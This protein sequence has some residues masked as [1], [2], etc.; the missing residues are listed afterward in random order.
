MAKRIRKPKPGF[1]YILS[2][3]DGSIFKYGVSINPAKRAKHISNCCPDH[4]F[5]VVKQYQV[6]D[7]FKEENKLRW[8]LV[9]RY[10]CVGTEFVY[11]E[12]MQLAELIALTEKTIEVN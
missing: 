4:V 6:K 7:M 1:V 9:G 11:R 3:Q 12:L 8:E 2:N 10:V 5:E